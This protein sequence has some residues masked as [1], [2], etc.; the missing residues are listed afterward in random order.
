ME[1]EERPCD[2][3]KK[4]SPVEANLDALERSIKQSRSEVVALDAAIQPILSRAEEVPVDESGKESAEPVECDLAL[5]IRRF[6]KMI[7]ETNHHIR[8]I[9]ERVQL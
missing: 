5:R 9:R 2:A 1:Q 8:S 7:F 3:P 6:E 4:M